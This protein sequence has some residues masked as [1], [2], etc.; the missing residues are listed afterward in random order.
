MMIRCHAAVNERPGSNLRDGGPQRLHSADG[1]AVNRLGGTAMKA[2]ARNTD[3]QTDRQ[4][5]VYRPFVQDYPGE[6]VPER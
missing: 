5:A 3:R 6:P 1:V 2:F 4:T